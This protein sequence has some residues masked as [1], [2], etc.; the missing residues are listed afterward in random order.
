MPTIGVILSD[1]SFRRPPATSE[2][3][4]DD[5]AIDLCGK[6]QPSRVTVW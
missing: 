3:P 4:K 2:V 1:T 6:V 5:E